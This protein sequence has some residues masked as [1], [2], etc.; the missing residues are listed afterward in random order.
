MTVF[1]QITGQ[2][3]G[4]KAVSFF[5]RSCFEHDCDR[6]L[7]DTLRAASVVTVSFELPPRNHSALDEVSQSRSTSN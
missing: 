3:S 1:F 6:G 5:N 7:A 4:E 2:E